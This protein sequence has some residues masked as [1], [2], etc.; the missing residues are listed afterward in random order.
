MR[1]LV[2]V[3]AASL[4]AGCSVFG[5]RSGYEQSAY[6]VEDT[7]DGGVE[8]RTYPARLAAETPLESD[9]EDARDAAFRRLFDYITGANQSR[10]DVAMTVP[11]EVGRPEQIAMTAP[12]ETAP[13]GDGEVMRFFLPPSYNAATAPAPTAA[14]VEIVELPPTKVAVLR[15]SG[16]WDEERFEAREAELIALL[17]G[18]AWRP[19]GSPSTLFYDPP[20]TLPWLRRNEAVVAVTGAPAT[21]S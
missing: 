21:G 7:V 19:V 15:F 16:L 4:L 3:V 1:I 6:A 11:V 17:Q 8:I 20:W 9:D 18:S 14:M 10:A 5:I 12:V 13:S 2:A